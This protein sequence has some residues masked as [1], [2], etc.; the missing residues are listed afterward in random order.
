[1]HTI[2]HPPVLMTDEFTTIYNAS[3][4]YFLRELGQGQW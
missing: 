4:N 2:F 1:M 3:D